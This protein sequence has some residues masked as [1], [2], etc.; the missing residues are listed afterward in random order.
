MYRGEPHAS[1]PIVSG[2]LQSRIPDFNIQKSCGGLAENLATCRL[3]LQ[4]RGALA[5]VDLRRV[6][7]AY[8]RGGL[9][10]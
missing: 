9:A 2:R 5:T 6:F 7:A 1:S 3:G 8:G 10:W 4:E